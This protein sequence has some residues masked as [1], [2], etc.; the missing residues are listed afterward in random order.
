MSGVFREG[1]NKRP[2]RNREPMV[3][4]RRA[5]GWRKKLPLFAGAIL[6]VMLAAGWAFKADALPM[7][8]HALHKAA[9]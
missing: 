4:E 2:P 5:Y 7:P 8:E 3:F 1:H 9:S 6:L